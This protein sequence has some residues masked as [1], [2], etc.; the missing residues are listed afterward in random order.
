MEMPTMRKLLKNAA[1]I[2][3]A[4]ITPTPTPTPGLGSASIA[5]PARSTDTP[6]MKISNR[7]VLRPIH[8]SQSI[9]E[10][11]SRGELSAV[12]PVW[13]AQPGF[14][15]CTHQWNRGAPASRFCLKSRGGASLSGDSVARASGDVA[16][17]AEHLLC[18][19]GVVGSI[20]IVSTIKAPG[21]SATGGFLV[22][23]GPMACTSDPSSSGDVCCRRSQ[24]QIRS[25]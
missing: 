7:F 11:R 3:P 2:T 19:Q 12:G 4:T 16:Q 13:S 14:R 8:L 5:P 21:S 9:G 25:K 15:R 18:K 22:S 23:G 17:L 20:P 24:L 1:T 10:C 6:R